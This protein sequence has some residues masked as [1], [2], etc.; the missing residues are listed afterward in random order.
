M[1]SA[2]PPPLASQPPGVREIESVGLALVAQFEEHCHRFKS[3]L[4][5]LYCLHQGRM[6]GMG[7]IGNPVLVGHKDKGKS[8]AFKVRV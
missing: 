4:R 6:D 8:Q 1:S 7:G 3:R 2:T 5:Y